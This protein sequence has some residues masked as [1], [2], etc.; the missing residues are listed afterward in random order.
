MKKLI[1]LLLALAMMIGLVACGAKGE[2]AAPAA[3]EAAPAA[4]EAA[5][6]ATE[7][8]PAEEGKDDTTK[9]RLGV[10]LYPSSNTTTQVC[11]TGFMET[12]EQLGMTP[13]YIGGDTTDS[14]AV[15]QMIDTAI[16]QYDDLYGV[17]LNI[18]SET[19]WQM[20]KKFTDASS[21]G[22]LYKVSGD[23]LTRMAQGFAVSV[24]SAQRVPSLIHRIYTTNSYVLD[25]YSA[26]T[27]GAL[28]DHR[29]TAGDIRQTLLFSEYS[30]M[31]HRAAVAGALNIP[32]FKLSE[33]L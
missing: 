32:E 23:T 24:V 4:T 26:L 13:L 27:F 20:A 25:S 10:V 22:R 28:Q 6:A 12:A 19:R 2:A 7:A 17:T 33:L 8:A 21:A 1:A 9:G 5:P 14:A 16:A 31:V 3:T 15:E 29:A 18:S 11:I 30:P